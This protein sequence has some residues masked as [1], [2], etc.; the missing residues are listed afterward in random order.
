[1][2]LNVKKMLSLVQQTL[3]ERQYLEMTWGIIG[4]MCDADRSLQWCTRTAGRRK[5]FEAYDRVAAFAGKDRRYMSL[6]MTLRRLSASD[7]YVVLMTNHQTRGR[8][9]DSS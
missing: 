5:T 9:R 8:G 7:C 6:K 1:M 3:E 4:R 2:L